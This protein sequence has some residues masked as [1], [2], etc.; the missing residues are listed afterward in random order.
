MRLRSYRSELDTR[1]ALEFIDA[2]QSSHYLIPWR[3]LRLALVL[4]VEIA[5]ENGNKGDAD[6]EF[7]R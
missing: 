6:R 4:L 5:D 3:R 1:A 7:D 2:A